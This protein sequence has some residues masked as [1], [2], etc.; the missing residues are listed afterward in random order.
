MQTL[1]PITKHKALLKF[2]YNPRFHSIF[3]AIV[4][5]NQS[6]KTVTAL[7]LMRCAHELGLFD[8]YGANIPD[9]ELGFEYDFIEDLPTLQERCQALNANG[10]HRYLFLG[11]EMGDWAPQDQSWLNVK[12]IQELQQVRKYG[13]SFIGCGIDRIDRRVVSPSFFNGVLRKINKLQ[14]DKGIYTDWTHYPVI[15]RYKIHGLPNQ[16]IKGFNTWRKSFFYFEKHTASK[17]YLFSNR[18]VMNAIA[19]A[20]GQTHKA[21]LEKGGDLS[22]QGYYN[23]VDAGILK[24]YEIAKSKSIEI[25]SKGHAK[26]KVDQEQ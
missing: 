10:L 4:G 24:L 16:T 1:T 13:L 19:K 11:D 12:L 20:E 2:L 15:K 9:L 7:Y 25:A 18:D 23:S 14:P 6:G 22:K 21:Y 26:A 5:P 3:T 8:W 17:D